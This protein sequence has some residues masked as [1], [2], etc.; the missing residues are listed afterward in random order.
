[1]NCFLHVFFDPR[2]IHV[3][4][5]AGTTHEAGTAAARKARPELSAED[6]LSNTP[7]VMDPLNQDRA[8]HAL[9]SRCFFP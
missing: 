9:G 7:G 3:L 5:K 1:M 2:S 6:P 4:Q 8:P